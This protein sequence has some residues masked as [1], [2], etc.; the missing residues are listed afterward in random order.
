MLGGS[1]WTWPSGVI[2]IAL[3]GVAVR[4][5]AHAFT[6]PVGVTGDE[7]YY[8]QVATSIASGE[9]HRSPLDGTRASWPPGYP[10]FLSLFIDMERPGLEAE[11][12]LFELLQ[13]QCLLG[14]VL[15]ALTAYLGRALFDARVGLLAAIVC[16][17]YPSLIAFSHYLFSETLF[18]VL[19]VAALWGV[20]AWPSRRGWFHAAG[21]GALFGLATLTREIALPV[22]VACALWWIGTSA[23]PIRRLAALQAALMLGCAMLVVAPWVVRNYASL[24][25]VVGVSSAAW[26]NVRSGNTFAG[27]SWLHP[28]GRALEGFRNT[29]FSIEDEMERSD[30][31]R[32]QALALIWEEQPGWIFK[33]AVRTIGGFFTPDSYLLKKISRGAYGPPHKVWVRTVLL[34]STLA[35]SAIFLWA[36]LG[37]F[38]ATAGGRR[39]LVGL[40]L[41]A[42]LSLHLVANVSPRYRL[43]FMPLMIIFA[44]AALVR[45]RGAW[46]SLD[47]SSRI[48]VVSVSVVF[49]GFC[50][51]YFYADAASLWQ[52]GS[53]VRPFRP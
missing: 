24:G 3:V 6:A 14:G 12:L 33:K 44:A 9:G 2:A 49:V 47:R 48:A 13:V 10:A 39:L 22:A 26:L 41:V 8:F 28:D 1:R 35:F 53:Y 52:V 34:S 43:P 20:V 27:E 25:R 19:L 16:A 42:V 29:Y 46:D 32:S 38:S 51:P 7:P 40:I 18:T 5:V 17:L 15:V 11:G 37:V 4:L 45:G 31:A 50:L 23:R 30:Y 36:V 21:I